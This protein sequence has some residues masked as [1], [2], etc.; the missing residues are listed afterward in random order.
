MLTKGEF[1][2]QL[3]TEVISFTNGLFHFRLFTL[4]MGKPEDNEII[5]ESSICPKFTL[6]VDSL[7]WDSRTDRNALYAL[8]KTLSEGHNAKEGSRGWQLAKFGEI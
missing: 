6:V 8:Y 3:K 7:T 4:D 2:A 1:V 5:L